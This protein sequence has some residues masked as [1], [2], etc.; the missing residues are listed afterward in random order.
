GLAFYSHHLFASFRTTLRHVKSFVAARMVFI[1][2]D[3]NHFGNH[4]AA[5]FDH[6]PV[7]DLHFQAINLILIMERGPRHGGAADGNGLERGHRGELAGAAHLHKNVFNPAGAAARSVLISNGPA[8]GFS[9]E[10][11]PLLR[12][13]GIYLDNYAINF[14]T[15]LV[16]HLL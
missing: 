10:A 3:L 16:A 4:V 5:T 8:W 6:H 2:D 13:R 11:E 1:V 9:G 15:K 7:A 12:A 14:V